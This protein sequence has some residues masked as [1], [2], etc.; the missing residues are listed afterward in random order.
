[1]L[2]RLLL[3]LLLLSFE[4]AEQEAP[5]FEETAPPEVSLTPPEE[6]TAESDDLQNDQPGLGLIEVPEL[7]TVE[8]PAAAPPAT[9]APPA[10]PEAPS[11]PPVDTPLLVQN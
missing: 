6:V 7:D 3:V 8:A 11:F 4:V 10:S 2:K 5:P 9:E 1:M